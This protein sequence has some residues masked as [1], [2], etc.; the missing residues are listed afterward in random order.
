[1]LDIDKIHLGD[2]LTLM[3]D[4][5]DKFCDAIIT[6]LPY[7]TTPLE[8]DEKIIPF[9]PL[10]AAYKRVIKPNGAIVLFCQQPFTTRLISSNMGMWKYNWIWMKEN[11]TNFLNSHYQPL[12]VTEDIAVFSFAAAAPTST[13]SQMEYHPQM[14]VGDAYKKHHCGNRNRTSVLRSMPYNKNYAVV[15]NVG[16]RMPTN[17]LYFP[18]DKEKLHPTGKPVDLLR[19]LIRTYTEEGMVVLDSCIG[20]GTT[21]IAAIKEKRHFIGIEIGEAYYDMACKR[22]KEELQQ[23]ELF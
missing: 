20:S 23:P 18:R 4:I 10:W 16:T 21:A 19:Y 9:E 5:P 6:D 14:G 13:N 1:M 7:N 15:E 8:W 2:C 3:Q 17:V 12:K 22:V 11:G